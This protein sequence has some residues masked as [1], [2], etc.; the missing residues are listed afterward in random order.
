[1]QSRNISLS[2]RTYETPTKNSKLSSTVDA[3]LPSSPVEVNLTMAR[4]QQQPR[5]S[6]RLTT[7]ISLLSLSSLN[8]GLPSISETSIKSMVVAS[9]SRARQSVST[10]TFRS[11]TMTKSTLRVS[12]P[13]SAM[14]TEERAAWTTNGMLI[15][16]ITRR[17]GI[18]TEL[19]CPM[20]A[21]SIC[22]PSTKKAM[23]KCV[24]WS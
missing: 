2:T 15:L 12:T 13:M 7:K 5:P 9:R 14:Y 16:I 18:G 20:R 3:A 21:P 23:I 11:L 8:N 22:K 10:L 19:K 1:M 4:N 6:T 24:E 17:P